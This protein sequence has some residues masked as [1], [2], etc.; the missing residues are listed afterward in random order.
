MAINKSST[1]P[2]VKAVIIMVA[3]A[4]IAV[5]VVSAISSSGSFGGS[6]TQTASADTYASISQKHAG[7]TQMYDQQLASEPT[8]Y[9]VLV[10]QGN[11]YYDWAAEVQASTQLAQSGADRPIW[12][13]ATSYYARALEVKSGDPAVTVDMAISYF[14]AGQTPKAIEAAESVMKTSPDFA[15][16]YF[17]GGVFYGSAGRNAEAVAAFEK[18]LQLDPQGASGKPDVAREQIA[19]LKASANTSATPIP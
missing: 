3:V 5:P 19:S 7:T 4:F 16:A 6:S 15:P 10:N 14:N 13:A 2:W 17:N 8:S 9:T 12:L 18:Y 1:P 11:A